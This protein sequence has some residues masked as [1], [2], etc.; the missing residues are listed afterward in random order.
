VFFRSILCALGFL[1]PA[2]ARAQAVVQLAATVRDFNNS[3]SSFNNKTYCPGTGYVKPVLGADRKPIPTSKIDSS[4]NIGDSA[5][6]A[7][8]WFKTDTTYSQSATTCINIPMTFDSTG[9]YTYD[10]QSFF[11]LD[12]FTTL[13]NGRP[14]PFDVTYADNNGNQRNF[15]FCA[16]MHGSF[17]YKAG[18]KFDF[19]GDDDVWFFIDNRLVVD[20]GGIHTAQSGRVNLDTMRLVEGTTY[21]WD[22]FY[23]ERHTPGS[24]MRIHT[25]MNLRTSSLFSVDDSAV[26]PG[27]HVYDLWVDQSNGSA[28]TEIS[29]RSRGTGKFV[30]SGPG[31]SPAEELGSGT[32]H[33]GITIDVD[34]GAVAV[35][36]AAIRG[37]RPGT[38]TL[39]IYQFGTDQVSRQ[40]VFTVPS[41]PPPTLVLSGPVQ[42]PNG[43]IV[44]TVTDSLSTADSVRVVVRAR[45]GDSL[46]LMVPRS[47][48]A[49]FT[50][51]FSISQVTLA[52][53]GDSVLDL[54]ASTTTDTVHA[55]YQDTVQA[56]SLVVP[57]ILHLRFRTA[58][59]T[60]QD[61]LGFVEVLGQ[62]TSVEVVAF[63][64]SEACLDCS[65]LVHV[66]TGDSGLGILSVDGREVDTVRLDSGRATILALGRSG[67]RLGS[68]S[69]AWDSAQTLLVARPISVFPPVPDSVDL[70]DEDGDGA[71]DRVVAHLAGPWTP[72]QSFT[73]PWTSRTRP[74]DLAEATFSLSP[75]SLLATWDF[76]VG[77][78]PD[79]T[80]SALPLSGFWSYANGWP[81]AYLK[82]REKIA[83]VPL[84]AR[85][86]HGPQADTLLLDPSE[87]LSVVLGGLDSLV[88]VA[89]GGI[90][91]G[92]IHPTQAWIAPSGELAL[93]LPAASSASEVRPGDS[94]RFLSGIGDLLGN[95]PGARAKSVVVEGGDPAPLDAI[96]YDTDADGR[97]DRA[98]L[99]LRAP[100]STTD[101]IDIRWPGS[102]GSLTTRSVAPSSVRTDS[103]GLVL[104]LDLEPFPFGSTSCP[105]TGCAALGTFATTRFTTP[106]SVDFPV[107]DGVDPIPL[108]ATYRYAVVA[109][110]PDTLV[111]LFSEPADT[112]AR[113][114]WVSVGRPGTD[115]L[116][117]VV[118][119]TAQP[120]LADGRTTARILVTG[121]G[122]PGRAGDSLRIAVRGTGTLSD[123]AGNT[124]GELAWWTPIV[125]TRPPAYLDVSVPRPVVRV[126]E[127]PGSAGQPSVSLLVRPDPTT[128]WTSLQGASPEE[129]SRPEYGGVVV[130]LN[131]IPKLLGVY[132][133][134]NTGVS[135]LSRNIAILE[136]AQASGQLV[137]TARG[138]YEVYFAWDGRDDAGR[139]VSSGV[140]LIRVHGWFEEGGSLHI[141]N[142]LVRQ[143]WSSDRRN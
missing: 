75:D 86:L 122:F 108:S 65:G 30:L 16:E 109:G 101:R 91:S 126:Q 121:T 116:G 78:S 39:G 49:S 134:D 68:I 43:R 41:W 47:G 1:L 31:L 12:S 115:S 73:V 42:G 34:L 111:V 82:I 77:R 2:V 20:L 124:P 71:L 50:R 24:D 35:D 21:P 123:T 11:P 133:Y 117:T 18:Q 58:A 127:A 102:D 48:P 84:R 53:A 60:V 83:Q 6:M 96:L 26:G 85:L 8:W 107:R 57:P 143:G 138:D 98:V 95:R 51:S 93:L 113:G 38:Y 45:S 29:T 66:G 5:R 136:D 114:P 32:W 120:S 52:V 28:C 67:V 76:A 62:R 23:C 69:F 142:R 94:V 99:R 63:L 80:S 27:H 3:D 46:V 15:S 137:P 89:Q 22:F 79:T 44:A 14:N 17:D 139:P 7:N 103:G 59:G 128:P 131:R 105:G 74:L 64:G 104:T 9:Y 90:L 72:G 4:C 97:A 112:T 87:T 106:Y 10:N 13:P 56:V 54:G 36:S 92:R 19:T 25:S 140:Y 88:G 70:L 55:A 129:V 119:P 37:L 81:A 141:L 135:V 118:S 33:G 40:V 130:K 110:L 100:L 61:T 132:I 125:W